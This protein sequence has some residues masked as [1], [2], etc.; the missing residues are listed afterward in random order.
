MLLFPDQTSPYQRSFSVLQKRCCGCTCSVYFRD[1]TVVG[2]TVSY[3]SSKAA[4]H[5]VSP[6]YYIYGETSLLIRFFSDLWNCVII[7]AVVC[8]V[9]CSKILI[10]GKFQMI[11]FFN[12]FL[13]C[14]HSI[15]YEHRCLPSNVFIR[16]ITISLDA[17]QPFSV[18]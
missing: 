16:F 15:I 5:R 10:K 8:L 4:K 13:L 9:T 18:H 7:L 12:I 1:S 14:T 6:I 2:E 11:I 17:T 3:C